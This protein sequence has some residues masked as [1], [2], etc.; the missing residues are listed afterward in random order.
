MMEEASVIYTDAVP[1]GK[2]IKIKK[3]LILKF[4]LFLISEENVSRRTNKY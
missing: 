3:V 1:K 4:Q 2:H